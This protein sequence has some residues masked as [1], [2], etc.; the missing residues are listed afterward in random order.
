MIAALVDDD[1]Q[2]AARAARLN[3]VRAAAAQR[4]VTARVAAFTSVDAG[5]DA[6]RLATEEDVA[7]LLLDAP[8][9]LLG[10][11]VPTGDLAAMLAGAP[12]DVALVAGAQRRDAAGDRP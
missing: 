6:V 11:G 3:A 7:L 12:C 5:A 4:G 9:A 2:L 8:E 1:T 10:G